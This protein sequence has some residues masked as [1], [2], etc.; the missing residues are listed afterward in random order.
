MAREWRNDYAYGLAFG[1][2]A[3]F[4]VLALGTPAPFFYFQF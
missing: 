1:A 3:G 2:L 4:A